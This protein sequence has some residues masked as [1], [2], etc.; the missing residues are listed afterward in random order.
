MSLALSPAERDALERWITHLGALKGRAPNT[1]TAYR[2]DVTG[3][4]ELRRDDTRDRV[5]GHRK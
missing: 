5:G 3:F 2:R 1:L 4:L